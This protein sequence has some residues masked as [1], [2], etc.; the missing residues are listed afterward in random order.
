MVAIKEAL[1]LA[2]HAEDEIVDDDDLH[3][4]VVV[5]ERRHL[6]AVHH[7]A[8]VA[9]DEDDGLV[10]TADLRAERRGQA[11]AHRAEAARRD[12]LARTTFR[13]ELRRPHL[14]LTDIRRDDR[15]IG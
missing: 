12:E 5:G 3:V 9:G 1:P 13:V 15:I 8:A 4:D 11:E 14:M 7:D 2:D 10:W 6:L